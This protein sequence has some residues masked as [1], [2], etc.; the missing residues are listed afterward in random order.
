MTIMKRWFHTLDSDGS[1][2]IGIE[3]L[4]DPLI[5]VGLAGSKAD[6]LHLIR[7]VDYDGNDEVS[8][9]EF[10]DLITA[11]RFGSILCCG[12]CGCGCRQANGVVSCG[13]GL[14]SQAG[15]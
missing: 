12:C 5:S 6:V 11:E 15:A 2:T 7:S 9:D 3:E 1:G 10:L 13:H 8:F 14:P 4:E